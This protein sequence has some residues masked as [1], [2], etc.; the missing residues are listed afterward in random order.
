MQ[1]TC[2]H[3]LDRSPRPHIRQSESGVNGAHVSQAPTLPETDLLSS[4]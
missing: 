1:L 3:S 4:S 2:F